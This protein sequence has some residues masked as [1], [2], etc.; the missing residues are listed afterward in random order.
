LEKNKSLKEEEAK[1]LIEIV[2]EKMREEN[3]PVVDVSKGYIIEKEYL[4][5]YE[6]MK[7]FYRNNDY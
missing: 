1:E 7:E 5:G 3:W 6:T 4:G 2:K